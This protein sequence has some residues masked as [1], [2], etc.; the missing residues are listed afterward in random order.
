[1]GEINSKISCYY[2]SKTKQTKNFLSWS[3]ASDFGWYAKK[4][5]KNPPKQNLH[6]HYFGLLNYN[7]S[8]IH[9]LVRFPTWK[10]RNWLEKKYKSK[11]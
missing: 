9:I 7:P 10:P 1:M 5:P 8:G 6:K 2:Y 3:V 4:T 11:Y